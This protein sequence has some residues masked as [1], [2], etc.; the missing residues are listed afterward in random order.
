MPLIDPVPGHE[1]SCACSI[2]V[3]D[4]WVRV[5][6]AHPLMDKPVPTGKILIPTSEAIAMA[7]DELD[8]HMSRIGELRAEL[9]RLGDMP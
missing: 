6:S 8:F 1:S 3:A 2:C 4:R 5:R 7:R 9:E